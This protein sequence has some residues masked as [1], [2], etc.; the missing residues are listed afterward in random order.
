M[1]TLRESLTTVA[2]EAEADVREHH[3]MIQALANACLLLLDRVEALES[4]S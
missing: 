1:I 3:A 2:V 4:K